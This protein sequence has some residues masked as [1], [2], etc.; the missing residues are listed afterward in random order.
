VGESFLTRL[1]RGLARARAGLGERLANLL[2][3]HPAVDDEFFVDLE[4][5][6]IQSDLG[7]GLS[8]GLVDE[9]RSYAKKER[10]A[11]GEEITKFLESRLVELLDGQ[12]HALQLA[13]QGVS[14]ILL[15]G[16]NGSG[17]TTT[18][19]KLAWRFT[20]EGR[21]VILCAADT[22]R[23]AAIDQLVIWGERVGAQVV[24]H[25]EGADPAAV[26]FDA[27]SAALARKADVL[28]VD[29]AGRLHTKS[30]LMQELAKVTRVIG[31]GIPGAPH[32]T[33]LVVDATTGMNGLEQARI[34]KE[35]TGVSGLVLTKLDGTARGGI[36]ITI[37]QALH[38]PVKLI[39]VGEQEDDLQDFDARAFVSAILRPR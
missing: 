4:E 11:G 33:L 2:Q 18:A 21:R 23:A 19:G 22:F 14:V 35:A 24:H 5:L 7:L 12:S 38:I 13:P 36:V 37:S 28:I 3:G 1:N 6:L 10:R 29:T 20:Q 25:Q 30:N 39:G 34:F 17:K 27:V 32:E 31:K 15:A 16:V 9:L 8:A 26:V